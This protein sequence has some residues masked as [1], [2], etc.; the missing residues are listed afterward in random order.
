MLKPSKIVVCGVDP[1]ISPSGKILRGFEEFALEM[2][3]ASVGVVWV[4][5][6]TRLQLDEPRRKLAISD[7]FTAEGGCGVY[8]P[9]DYFHLR[10]SKTLRLGRFTC[11]PIA[12]LQPAAT[13]ALESLSAETSVPVVPLRSLSPRELSQNAGLSSREAELIRQR[14][15]D[16]LFFFA[17][18]SDS[19]IDGFM[20]AARAN[21]CQLNR[22]GAFWS[23]AVG[24][25]LPRCLRELFKL[26]ERAL[27][28]RPKIIGLAADATA[29]ELFPM[30]GHSFFLTPSTAAAPQGSNG[31]ITSLPLNDV[32]SWT[33]AATAILAAS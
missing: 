20:A 1:F 26:Y 31:Q 15:F 33:A 28:S 8:L 10:P 27:R 17:G 9:E 22:D 32:A 3:D 7:P 24:A 30:C 21:N 19:G 18:A 14:D 6:R 23:L 16:E 25:S 2:N 11:I 5:R 4:S 12:D 13:E 29:A